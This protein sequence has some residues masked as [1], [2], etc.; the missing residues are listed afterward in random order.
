[1]SAKEERNEIGSIQNNRHDTQSQVL[2]LT[3]IRSTR[4]RIWHSN[5]YYQYILDQKQAVYLIVAI[6]QGN[7]LQLFRKESKR[8]AYDALT[9]LISRLSISML[10]R[11][12]SEANSQDKSL[13]FFKETRSNYFPRNQ[14]DMRMMLSPGLYHT[15]PSACYPGVVLRQTPKSSHC[16][17]SRKFT[18]T[19]SQGIKEI[20]V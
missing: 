1:V 5:N 12:G 19:I 14:R 2:R 10:S 4:A 6:F 11:C 20:C 7:S 17:F 13:L 16:H 18:L 8:Y 15:C 9:Q 3:S